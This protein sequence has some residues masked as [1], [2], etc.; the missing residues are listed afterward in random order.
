MADP[1][2][3]HFYNEIL[4]FIVP[5]RASLGRALPVT[6]QRFVF[7]AEYFPRPITWTQLTALSMQCAISSPTGIQTPVYTVQSHSWW[8][9]YPNAWA[10]KADQY[11][12]PTDPDHVI[13]KLLT[14]FLWT[15]HVTSKN[16]CRHLEGFEPAT[17][18]FR[19]THAEHSSASC[20][21]SKSGSTISC[22]K[23]YW[24]S[25]FNLYSPWC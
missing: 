24:T 5:K 7:R 4:S 19:S 23:F 1:G 2:L 6:E 13:L 18:I 21:K 12:V 17:L 15:Y 8:P 20:R 9:Q 16:R 11:P 10:I 14:P 25:F 3:G 22:L